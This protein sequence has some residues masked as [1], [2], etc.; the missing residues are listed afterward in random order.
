MP[1][2]TPAALAAKPTERQPP[3][4]ELLHSPKIERF[5]DRR[6]G[7]PSGSLLEVPMSNRGEYPTT[8]RNHR[9]LRRLFWI[10]RAAAVAGAAT[11]VARRF[12]RRAASAPA[13][14]VPSDNTTVSTMVAVSADAGYSYQFVV[15]EGAAIRCGNCSAVRPASQFPMDAL[16]RMEGA[17]D[18]DDTVAVIAVRCPSCDAQGTMVLNYGPSGSPEESDVLL[19]L[20]D[21]RVHSEVAA[22]TAPGEANGR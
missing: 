10:A 22:G 16:R 11:A 9:L 7:Y 5:D 6:R 18:P 3:R 20:D 2:A 17:S 19:A 15:Q 21:N 14:G 13:A 1:S 12:L 4:N 8:H